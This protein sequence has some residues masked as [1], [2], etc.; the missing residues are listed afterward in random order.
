MNTNHGMKFEIWIISIV[1]FLSKFNLAYEFGEFSDLNDQLSNVGGEGVKEFISSV[2]NYEQFKIPSHLDSH[3]EH[4]FSTDIS[5]NQSDIKSKNKKRRRRRRKRKKKPVPVSKK[6]INQ[7]SA[8]RQH[9]IRIPSDDI[10]K[11]NRF[12]D[13]VC[14]NAKSSDVRKLCRRNKTPRNSNLSF[15]SLFSLFKR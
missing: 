10:T 15:T 11:Y 2:Q 5:T 9:D 14:K 4:F 12:L 7:N 6:P 3:S 8:I 13:K 1:G